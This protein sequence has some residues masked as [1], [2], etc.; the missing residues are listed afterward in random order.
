MAGSIQ[1]RS[2]LEISEGSGGQYS[3]SE[4]AR[5]WTVLWMVLKAVG[6]TASMA[7]SPSSLPVRVSWQHGKKSFLAGLTPNPRFYEMIMGWP[8]GWTDAEQPVTE[9]P[10]WLLRSRGLFSR[11]LSE[12]NERGLI[13]PQETS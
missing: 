4:A 5:S 2:P 12:F 1:P 9:F 6:W 7:T 10:A 11:L 13:D 8:I 3:L